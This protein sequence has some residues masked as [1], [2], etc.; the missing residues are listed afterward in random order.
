MPNSAFGVGVYKQ[1]LFALH[2]KA[3]PQIFAGCGL[4]CS[5]LLVDNSDYSCF[6]GH[7]VL[8]PFHHSFIAIIGGLVIARNADEA[9]FAAHRVHQ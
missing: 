3:H 6:W 1:D 5:S 7:I 8:L 2:G 4:T 9:A